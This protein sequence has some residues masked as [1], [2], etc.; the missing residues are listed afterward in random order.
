MTQ[1]KVNYINKEE[2]Y[3]DLCEWKAR[4]DIAAEAGKKLP[5]LPNSVGEAIIK[6]ADRM[7]SRPNFRNYTYIED[8][9]GDGIMDMVKAANSFDPN[10]VNKSGEKNPFGF[11]SLVCWQAFLSRIKHEKKI[12]QAKID[13]MLDP[14]SE[15]HYSQGEDGQEID[16]SGMAQFLYENRV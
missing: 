9:R 8:M 6:I 5:S 14:T 4:K 12:Q 16:T 3:A 11:F 7:A 1:V 2:L 10:R 13:S 15:M